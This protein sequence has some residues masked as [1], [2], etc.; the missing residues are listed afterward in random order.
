MLRSLTAAAFLAAFLLH[1]GA[2]PPAPTVTL[3]R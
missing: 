3:S 1:A 2:T